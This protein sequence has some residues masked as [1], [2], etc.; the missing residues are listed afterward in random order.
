[1]FLRKANQISE[2]MS[3]FYVPSIFGEIT[4]VETRDDGTFSHGDADMTMVS[5]VL[6]KLTL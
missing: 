5:F 6:C 3:V 4:T 1:M 2:N